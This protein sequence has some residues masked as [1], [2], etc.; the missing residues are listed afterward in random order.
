MKRV[1][2][3]GGTGGLGREVV[4]K[5][6]KSGYTVRIMSRQSQTASQWPEVEWIQADLA[7]GDGLREAVVGLDTIIYAATDAGVTPENATFNTFLRKTLLRHDSSV[8]VQGTK[9]LL[10]Q[11]HANR[12][13][14]CIY[15]SIVGIEHIPFAYYRHKLAAEAVVRESGVLWSIVRA[16]QF[17][18]LIETFIR[19]TAKWPALALATDLQFQS[20][21][22]SEV[23]SYLCECVS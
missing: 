6:L 9:L 15:I 17:H 7:T 10:E 1:L 21:D 11:A 23:A 4:H 5:L 14:H 13:A 20:V 22:P 18:S 3:T 2:V 12:V 16:T 19:T 8:D